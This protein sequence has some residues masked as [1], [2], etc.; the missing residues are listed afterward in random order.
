MSQ[1]TGIREHGAGEQP[2]SQKK[3]TEPGRGFAVKFFYPIFWWTLRICLAIYHWPTFI[4]RE[5][6]P[7][8][9]A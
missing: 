4:G 7:R 1:G 9:P 3:K 8:A 5:N 2:A 6:R